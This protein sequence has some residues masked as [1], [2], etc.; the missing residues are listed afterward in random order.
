MKLKSFLEQK[1][2]KLDILLFHYRTLNIY[3]YWIFD[4]P[5]QLSWRRRR[6]PRKNS[7]IEKLSQTAFVVLEGHRWWLKYELPSSNTSGTCGYRERFCYR[8]QVLI[9]LKIN[10]YM[11]RLAISVMP[12]LSKNLQHF[13]WTA[14]ILE[15]IQ[16]RKSHWTEYP[17]WQQNYNIQRMH[18]FFFS[19]SP[20]TFWSN[21][22]DFYGW[23][24]LSRNYCTR[25]W[26]VKMPRS[27]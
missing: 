20:V 1:R 4:V 5:D 6:H 23:N 17:H 3:S 21:A 26:P 9:W 25:I 16:L 13:L 8:I 14:K 10:I 15:M 12:F 2:T 27:G 24:C 19:H 22:E 18:Q 7:A 11:P